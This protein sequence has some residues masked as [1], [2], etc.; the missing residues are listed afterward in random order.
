MTVNWDKGVFGLNMLHVVSSLIH[1]WSD[2]N[3]AI[4]LCTSSTLGWVKSFK[5]FMGPTREILSK[6]G[7]GSPT[8]QDL[9]MSLVMFL[10]KKNKLSIPPVCRGGNRFSKV[11]LY[12]NTGRSPLV[13]QDPFEGVSM[14]VWRRWGYI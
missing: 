2:N 1:S 11:V 6:G 10:N 14:S 4:S 8:P 5:V 3:I 7:G 13:K 12:M 9:C